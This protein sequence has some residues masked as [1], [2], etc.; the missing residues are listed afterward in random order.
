[1]KYPEE[2]HSKFLQHVGWYLYK[3]CMVPY[4]IKYKTSAISISSVI[5]IEPPLSTNHPNLK[6]SQEAFLVLQQCNKYII[7]PNTNLLFNV[8]STLNSFV[9]HYNAVSLLNE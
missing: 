3:K 6:R 2:R 7:F 1:M 5:S 9:C 8:I 4:P